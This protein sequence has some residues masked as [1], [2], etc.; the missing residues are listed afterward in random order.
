[1]GNME[2]PVLLYVLIGLALGSIATSLV[3][4]NAPQAQENV[5]EIERQAKLEAEHDMGAMTM[6]DMTEILKGKTGDAYDKAFI[7]M[8]IAH[9]EGAV[10]MAELTASRSVHDEIKQL[11]QAIIAAQ[12]KEIAEMK[13]WYQAWGYGEN[14]APIED[15][16]MMGH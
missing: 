12:T 11:S 2:K 4:L 3:F 13:A 7:E 5:G 1:M 10:E 6:D 14:G 16:M 8:M 15:G 9:H